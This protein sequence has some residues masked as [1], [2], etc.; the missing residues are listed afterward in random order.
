MEKSQ[1][2]YNKK[3]KFTLNRILPTCYT[4]GPNVGTLQAIR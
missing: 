3:H 4:L 2:N 1:E